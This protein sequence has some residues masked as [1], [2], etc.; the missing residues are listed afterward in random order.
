[1]HLLCGKT[2]WLEA[3]SNIN[4]RAAVINVVDRAQYCFI[5]R[6]SSD[7]GVMHHLKM[8]KGVKNRLQ[9]VL[10]YTGTIVTIQSKC[11]DIDI[12]SDDWWNRIPACSQFIICPSQIPNLREWNAIYILALQAFLRMASSCPI[13]WT[14]LLPRQWAGGASAYRG[15]FFTLNNFNHQVWVDVLL[16]MVSQQFLA[17]F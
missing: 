16:I 17:F 1:M 5:T 13:L 10:S 15:E 14:I 9:N 2:T 3:I 7:V 11:Y 4:I 8:V 6:T 12:V